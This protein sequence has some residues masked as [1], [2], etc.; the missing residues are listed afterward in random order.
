MTGPLQHTDGEVP[1]LGAL[2]TPGDSD[3]LRRLRQ[4][5][6]TQADAR[7]DLDVAYR[8]VDSPIG[9]LLLAATPIGLCRVAFEIEDHE[10]VLDELAAQIGARVLRSAIRLD[11]VARALA[12]YFAGTTQAL[13]TTLDLR[14]T[15]G[16]RRRVLE[17]LALVGYG[18][19]MGYGELAAAVGSPRAARAVGTACATNPIPLVIPCHRVVRSDGGYGA[20][21]GGEPAKRF[22]LE[23]ERECRASGPHP[24]Q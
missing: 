23:F 6:A 22:L 16:F 24:A 4:C 10:G 2:E 12:D 9:P 5:L 7:G 14:L 11:G 19:R 20:Y 1:E 13:P 3:H 17:R 18:E 21:R 15:H 8:V